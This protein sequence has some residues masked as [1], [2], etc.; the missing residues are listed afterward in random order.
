MTSETLR[1]AIIS[2]NIVDADKNANLQ[3]TRNAISSLTRAEIDI[4]VLPELFSTGYVDDIQLVRR[5]AENNSGP[6]LTE[7]KELSSTTNIAICG[8][9]IATDDDGRNFFNRCFFITPGGELT[10]YDK[11]HLF[12]L[13]REAEIFTAGSN[14]PPVAQYRGWKIALAVCYDL[15]FPCWLR[16]RVTDGNLSY[17]LLLLPANWPQDRGY[18][19]HQ[20]LIARGIENQAY[21]VGANRSGEDK[22]GLYDGLTEIVDYK[23]RVMK[24]EKLPFNNSSR[25]EAE[26]ETESGSLAGPDT[27]DISIYILSKSRMERFRQLFPVWRSAD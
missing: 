25:F 23:G 13:G 14:M 11:R 5:L 12:I 3:N 18:A 27:A 16:N 15:R 9:F 2:L 8:S 20:L 22:F 24:S 10:T 1:T 4:A 19:W 7:L 17:D 6:T 21:I 26:T